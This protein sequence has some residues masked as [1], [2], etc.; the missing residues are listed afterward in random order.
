MKI[1]FI[2]SVKWKISISTK[3]L[4]SQKSLK[5][6]AVDPELAINSSHI[7]LKIL[8]KNNKHLIANGIKNKMEKHTK[9]TKI[10]KVT[11]ESYN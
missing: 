7:L 1:K 4:K 9:H 11:W 2:Y 8:T 3:L 10:S 5:Y 6:L